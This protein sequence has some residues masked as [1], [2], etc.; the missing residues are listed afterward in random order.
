MI[1]ALV[2]RNLRKLDEIRH[3]GSVNGES[4][5]TIGIT[6]R[7]ERSSQ[8]VEQAGGLSLGLRV[9]WEAGERVI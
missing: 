7:R 1:C 6:T 8:G 4:L 9:F 2:D 5:M 3:V